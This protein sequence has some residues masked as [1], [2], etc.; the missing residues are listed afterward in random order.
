MSNTY[1][2]VVA[3]CWTLGPLLAQSGVNGRRHQSPLL[4]ATLGTSNP[5][6]WIVRVSFLQDSLFPFE[7]WPV[8]F[9]K[10]IER[11]RLLRNTDLMCLARN[12]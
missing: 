5:I 9:Q 4:G 3:A 12:Q 11:K 10:L 1:N 2:G 6:L 8:P 7:E